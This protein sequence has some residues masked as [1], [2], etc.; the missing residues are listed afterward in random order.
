MLDFGLC[1]RTIVVA[2]GIQKNSRS[3]RILDQQD[4]RHTSRLHLPNRS[5]TYW[6]QRIQ[7]PLLGISAC[8]QLTF[9]Q[10]VQTNSKSPEGKPSETAASA[11]VQYSENVSI[12]CTIRD[13]L[14][15]ILAFFGLVA[16]NSTLASSLRSSY[17]QH[18]NL[19]V[20]NLPLL[21]YPLNPPPLNPQFLTYHLWRLRHLWPIPFGM[22]KAGFIRLKVVSRYSPLNP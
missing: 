10:P 13:L 15:S 3:L 21:G 8:S 1:C 22:W 2:M 20:R 5:L 14:L 19:W 6:H 4:H 12:Y 16:P 11:K 9:G 7:P 17:E 18:L